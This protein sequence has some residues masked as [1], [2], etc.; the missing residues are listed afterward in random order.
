ML[1]GSFTVLGKKPNNRKLRTLTLF[2]WVIVTSKNRVFSS[3][4]PSNHLSGKQVISHPKLLSGVPGWV[5]F[6]PRPGVVVQV[7]HCRCGQASSFP[8]VLSCPSGGLSSPQHL[9]RELVSFIFFLIK[10][11]SP[12]LGLSDAFWRGHLRRETVSP[13]STSCGW[14]PAL[15]PGPWTV[16]RGGPLPTGSGPACMMPSGRPHA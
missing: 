5:L 15:F 13:V 2:C 9:L 14:C 4:F 1:E 10:I 11:L 8:P 6:P 16:V 3:P 7:L 12:T